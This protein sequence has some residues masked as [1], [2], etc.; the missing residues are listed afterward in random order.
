MPES[1]HYARRIYFNLYLRKVPLPELPFHLP[2]KCPEPDN[3]A[4]FYLNRAHG[5]S[6]SV[7]FLPRNEKWTHTHTS[8]QYIYNRA[9]NINPAL[10]VIDSMRILSLLIV[11][12]YFRWKN[13]FTDRDISDPR[14]GTRVRKAPLAI[15]LYP[16]FIFS[17]SGSYIGSAPKTNDRIPSIGPG[18]GRFRGTITNAGPSS[19]T[20]FS[21]PGTPWLLPAR[22]S[23][24]RKTAC[25]RDWT[26]RLH[27]TGRCVRASGSR[28]L[29]LPSTIFPFT[30][31]RILLFFFSAAM[32]QM[33]DFSDRGLI[34]RPEEIENKKRGGLRSLLCVGKQMRE[35]AAIRKVY[36]PLL[37]TRPP[38]FDL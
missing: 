28:G 20:N 3:A 36:E 4:D 35:E 13:S 30:V 27:P 18:F 11:N 6:F 29:F 7:S 10:L 32:E 31:L 19:S 26:A 34:T 16:H 24:A 2:Y 1:G 37:S 12:I 9:T 14:R 8:C 38:V 21:C 25:G 23:A 17:A 33:P 5:H 22:V 15:H